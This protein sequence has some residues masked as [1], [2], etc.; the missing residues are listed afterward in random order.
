M[1]RWMIAAVAVV[2]VAT[3]GIWWSRQGSSADPTKYLTATVQRG[4]VVQ[5][6]AAT[7][8]VSP[9]STL[10]LSFGGTSAGSGSSSGSGSASTG[11]TGTGS[12][13]SSSQS[14]SN[15][16]AAIKSVPVKVGQSVA[17]GA[18]LATI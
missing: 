11:S 3:G 1:R 6:V 9:Q 18:V 2:A 10:G 5:T 8:T 15:G 7:G 12:G 4:N 16:S 17:A 14:V 13:S